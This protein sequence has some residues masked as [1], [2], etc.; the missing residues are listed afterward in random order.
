LPNSQSILNFTKTRPITAHT[1]TPTLNI[2]PSTVRGDFDLQL[3]ADEAAVWTQQIADLTCQVLSGTYHPR[4]N[5]LGHTGNQIPRG[6]RAHA[7]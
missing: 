5:M 6:P 1:L 3:Q 2:T 7:I 4:Q